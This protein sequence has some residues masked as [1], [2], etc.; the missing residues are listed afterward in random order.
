MVQSIIIATAI[1]KMFSFEQMDS[2]L[3]AQENQPFQMRCFVSLVIIAALIHKKSYQVFLIV[4]IL[5]FLVLLCSA[6]QKLA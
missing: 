6:S 3:V 4:P 2:R 1:R 5:R